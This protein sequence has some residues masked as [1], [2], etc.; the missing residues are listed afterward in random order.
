[1]L[2]KVEGGDD[3]DKLKHPKVILYFTS[4]CSIRHTFEDSCAVHAILRGFHIAIDDRWLDG[5]KEI[6]QMHEG[7]ELGKML[8]GVK[9]V[10]VKRE[11]L[12]LVSKLYSVDNYKE[13]TNSIL[14][15]AGKDESSPCA[16][17]LAARDVAQ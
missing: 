10:L 12:V 16:A 6:Q 7:R 17:M 8:E 11:T 5:S 1:M 3:A 9:S 14:T 2:Q 4:L 15:K 13:V